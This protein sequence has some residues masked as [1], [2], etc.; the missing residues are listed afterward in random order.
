MIGNTLVNP[1]YLILLLLLFILICELCTFHNDTPDDNMELLAYD[2]PYIPKNIQLKDKDNKVT[3]HLKFRFIYV[4]QESVFNKLKE[5]NNTST[6]NNNNIQ[7][8]FSYISN[9]VKYV[10]FFVVD[11]HVLKVN[12][13]IRNSIKRYTYKL[14]DTYVMGDTRIFDDIEDILICQGFD[15][16][17]YGENCISTV[18]LNEICSNKIEYIKYFLKH[19]L[20]TSTSIHSY[21][22]RPKNNIFYGKYVKAP[23]SSRSVCASY[24]K[25]GEN[26]FLEDGIIIQEKNN[27]LQ[28]YELKCYVLDGNIDMII[29]RLHGKNINIC[30]PDDYKNIPDD[31]K[32]I[33]EQY[34][35]DMKALCNKAYYCINALI[36][37]RIEKLHNDEKNS[38]LLL[39]DLNMSGAKLTNHDEKKIKYILTGLVNSEKIKLINLINHK[40]SKT[41]DYSKYTKRIVDYPDPLDNDSNFKIY[42][43]FMRIDIALP[44]NNKYTHL[45]VTEIEPFASGIYMYKTVGGCMKSNDLN[46]FDDIVTYNLYRILSTQ[47]NSI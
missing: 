47:S 24:E 25:V 11:H 5:L 45:T 37:M 26:C 33:V 16:D 44:D 46:I 14:Y 32:N 23:Y 1:Y 31:I 22:N 2:I 43:R 3:R 12:K 30:V 39:N 17:A 29:V 35:D 20:M 18:Y 13:N 38:I 27:M 21:N 7:T 34:K 4:C 41:Y 40:Y 36:N 28:K 42:D 6:R 19:G 8:L 15:R 9:D 10:C